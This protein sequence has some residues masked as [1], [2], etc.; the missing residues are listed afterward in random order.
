MPNETIKPTKRATK[1]QG[2]KEVET[3]TEETATQ[4]VNT[5]KEQARQMT[6]NQTTTHDEFAMD[7]YLDIAVLNNEL[8]TMNKGELR[9]KVIKSGEYVFP[10]TDND[11]EK[12]P[13]FY[14]DGAPI[15]DDNGEQAYEMIRSP[16][17]EV[18][19][20]GIAGKISTKRLRKEELEQLV[21]QQTYFGTYILT[22]DDKK[23]IQV[24]F[25]SVVPFQQELK[26]RAKAL[27]NG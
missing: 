7:K 4:E 17:V 16:Y 26:A 14:D 12:I 19:G 8:T 6:P 27:F 2:V 25:T 10:K 5:A 15:F 23:N 1:N 20:E 13:L 3:V 11:G 9:F 24:E 21:E 18:T 22:A